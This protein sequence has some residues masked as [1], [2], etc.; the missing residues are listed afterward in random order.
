[1]EIRNYKECS[2][3]TVEEKDEITIIMA[4]RTSDGLNIEKLS[5]R[6]NFIRKA[7]K[8]LKSGFMVKQN[9]IYS[10]TEKAF[11]ISNSILCDL[12]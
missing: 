10:L 7:Q 12:I 1:M 2:K 6:D 4:L 8:Y 5:C 9:N 11:Y 3:M